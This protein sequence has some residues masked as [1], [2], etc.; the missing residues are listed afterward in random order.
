MR[1]YSTFQVKIRRNQKCLL[2]ENLCKM[3]C[4]SWE[5]I[6]VTITD[7]ATK[8]SG[9]TKNNKNHQIHNRVVERLS[10]Q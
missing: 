7:S 6:Q 8:A 1:S 2:E 9:F 3:E 10:N 4:T 5:N